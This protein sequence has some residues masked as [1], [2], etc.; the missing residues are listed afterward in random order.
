M[1][2]LGVPLITCLTVAQ[3]QKYYGTIEYGWEEIESE[4]GMSW[5][6]GLDI[7]L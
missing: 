6:C 4:R 1:V 5:N 7:T 2:C 3:L